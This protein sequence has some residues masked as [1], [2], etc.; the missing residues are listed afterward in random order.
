MNSKGLSL[1]ELLIAMSIIVIIGL[2][3]VPNLLNY[4]RAQDLDFDAKAIVA[5]LR[6]AQQ[7]AITQED[8]APG[9]QWG[10][11][12]DNTIS[13]QHFYAVFKGTVYPGTTV[14]RKP[15]KS[16]IEFYSIPIPPHVFLENLT[17]LPV[18]VSSASVTIRIKNASCPSPE[19][20]TININSNGTFI[21]TIE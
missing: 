21:I 14:L 16:S 5:A 4:R 12:F 3:I 17:G 18:S 11:R 15:L 19:C 1:V 2:L 7:R 13:G 8:L 9:E 10:V 20:K 6:D